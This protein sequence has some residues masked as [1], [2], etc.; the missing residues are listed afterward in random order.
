MTGS[1]L[2]RTGIV[3]QARSAYSIFAMSELCVY[4]HSSIGGFGFANAFLCATGTIIL[5]ILRRFSILAT[6]VVSGNLPAQVS[7]KHTPVPSSVHRPKLVLGIVVDQFRYGYTTRFAARYSGGLHTLL[8]Q[9]AVF[10]DAHQDHY[11]TVPAT[12][13][14]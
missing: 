3:G 9:G 1:T 13:P 4:R 10:V 5:R 2:E 8:T 14:S 7:Q 11:P 6:I 12:P